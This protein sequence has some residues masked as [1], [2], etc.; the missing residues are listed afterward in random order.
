MTVFAINT[1]GIVTKEIRGFIL[2]IV[3]VCCVAPETSK[4]GRRTSFAGC[5]DE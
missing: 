4:T 5:A 3:L 2:L 1:K